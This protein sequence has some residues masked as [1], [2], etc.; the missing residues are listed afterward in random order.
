ME[1]F[2]NWILLWVICY[3]YF[4]TLYGVTMHKFYPNTFKF[5]PLV[6]LEK[7]YDD[8]LVIWIKLLYFPDS[9]FHTN[10]RTVRLFRNLYISRCSVFLSRDPLRNKLRL[11][12]EDA[13]RSG[14]TSKPSGILGRLPFCFKWLSSPKVVPDVVIFF[15]VSQSGI[16]YHN[17]HSTKI[18]SFN[19]R[20]NAPLYIL[21]LARRLP[22]I[23]IWF[24]SF[25]FTQIY[26]PT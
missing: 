4:I 7:L 19:L 13:W 8:P 12:R 22:F 11:F 23:L 14:G 1:I 18:V 10:S 16:F 3:P 9:H 25:Q 2:R 26:V 21:F 17:C 6:F 24:F 20:E 5:K 15:P